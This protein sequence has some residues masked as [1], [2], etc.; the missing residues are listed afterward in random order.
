[1]M[2]VCLHIFAIAVSACLISCSR[3]LGNYEYRPLEG[4][5]VSGIEDS[6]SVLAFSR[7]RIAPDFGSDIFLT[8]R[9]GYEWRTL[10]SSQD[11]EIT[12]VSTDA[13]LD[14]EVSL[15]AGSYT[16]YFK[17][18][19]R[20]TGVFWQTESRLE[21]RET[22][23]EGWMVLCRDESGRVDLEM[24]SSVTGETYRNI[25]Q[26]SG[27]E[28]PFGPKMIEWSFYADRESPFY[29]LTEDLTTRLSR[30]SF[31]WSDQYLLKY[32][33]GVSE[34]P[35]ADCIV[36]GVGE[37]LMIC[38][39]RLYRAD[40][41]VGIGLFGPVPSEYVFAP[42]VGVNKCSR[43]IIVPAYLLFDNEGKR[44]IAYSPALG[45]ED[46]GRN[47]VMYEMNGF[48]DFLSGMEGGGA[49]TGNAFDTFPQGMDLVTMQSSSY[50][51]DNS[52]MGVIYSVLSDGTGYYVYGV[53][54][55]EMWGAVQ[56][57]DCAYAVGL[58]CYADVSDCDNIMD[59]SC[60]AFSPLKG[61][62]YYSCGGKL[63]CVDLNVGHPGSALQLELVGEEI[64]CL[65]FHGY[66]L[67]VASSASDGGR[68]RI[69][70]GYDS[71]GNFG[72]VK[73]ECFSGLG[74]IV[75]IEYREM[76]K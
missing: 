75:D 64:V 51:P 60:F 50:D 14:W 17:V 48:L 26:S 53:Q 5:S 52:N 15:P 68:L 10:G 28:A 70:E 30:N 19:D 12:T 39:G 69:Y 24:V 6:Y 16:L 23:S 38:D 33:M 76:L 3:D 9:Y 4:P 44:F 54:L 31:A 61:A 72:S 63:Y 62:M 57:G 8:D 11:A 32:E 7:L 65:E 22:T 40:C 73:P 71:D 37:K 34:T 35:V 58:S 49:V 45:T 20:E 25:L 41:I 67:A 21:I 46:L 2:R 55:G 59:A 27:L 66:D 47:E 18:T 36:D 42:F 56:V 43:S 29:L 13:I 1:M 74:E